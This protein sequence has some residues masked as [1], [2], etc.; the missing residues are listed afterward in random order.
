MPGLT[1]EWPT[2]ITSD[3]TFDFKWHE[4]MLPEFWG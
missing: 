2:G 4:R 1:A 3:Y